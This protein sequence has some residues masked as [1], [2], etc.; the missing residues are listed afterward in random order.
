MTKDMTDGDLARAAIT[1]AGDL[2][3]ALANCQA[4]GLDVD[5]TVCRS[6][7]KRTPEPSSIYLQLKINRPLVAKLRRPTE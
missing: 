1:K 6:P 4:A 7:P 3:R 5:L 2:E